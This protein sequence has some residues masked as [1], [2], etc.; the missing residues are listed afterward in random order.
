M[1]DITSNMTFINSYNFYVISQLKIFE[2]ILN[3]ENYK[4]EED[5]FLY[6]IHKY[7]E[8][9]ILHQKLMARTKQI[10]WRYKK[11]HTDFF[12]YIPKKNRKRFVTKVLKRIK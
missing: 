7:G 10:I 5:K 12:D 1:L 9:V 3:F 4:Y 2:V 11:M 8:E 6:K